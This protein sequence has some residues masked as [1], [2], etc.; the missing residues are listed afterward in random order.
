MKLQE[1][2]IELKH[3]YS[4][5]NK[6]WKL[7]RKI[8]IFWNELEIPINYK[9][10]T[11]INEEKDDKTNIWFSGRVP[12]IDHSLM[13]GIQVPYGATLKFKYYPE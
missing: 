5:W 10:K 9:E 7:V 12:L 6:N 13:A 3:W 1:R 8:F 4:P 11:F 2:N